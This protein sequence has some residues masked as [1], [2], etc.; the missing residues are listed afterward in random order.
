MKNTTIRIKNS[1]LSFSHGWGITYAPNTMTRLWYVY[2]SAIQ[3][4][5]PSRYITPCFPPF[6]QLQVQTRCLTEPTAKTT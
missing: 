6:L 5:N 1:W 3:N 4:H 2:K